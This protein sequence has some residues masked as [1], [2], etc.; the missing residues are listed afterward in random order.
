MAQSLQGMWRDLKTSN[1]ISSL[2]NFL[3]FPL[4]FPQ[5][6]SSKWLKIFRSLNVREP[7][8]THAADGLLIYWSFYP[9]IIELGLPK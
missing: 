7:F 2:R 1:I 3:F 4:S 8:V 5:Q 6:L 9:R